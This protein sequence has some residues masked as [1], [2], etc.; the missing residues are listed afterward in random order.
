MRL[1]AVVIILRK[2]GF[3]HT[4][5]AITYRS[6]DRFKGFP[7]RFVPAVRKG[8]GWGVALV[9]KT[10]QVDTDFGISTLFLTD[11]HLKA[12]EEAFKKSDELT[13]ELLGHGW[14]GQRPFWKVEDFM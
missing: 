11:G 10:S 13:H 9:L 7:Y 6:Y 2:N 12:V 4:G 14:N 8:N 3:F 5:D 1:R